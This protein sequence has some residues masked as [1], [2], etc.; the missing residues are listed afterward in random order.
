[1]TV[2][3][4]TARREDQQ[5]RIRLL[6]LD[7]LVSL[8]ALLWCRSSR[9]REDGRV[10][11]EDG[12]ASRDSRWRR[13]GRRWREVVLRGDEVRGK[14]RVG[15]AFDLERDG[16]KRGRC[17]GG[18]EVDGGDGVGEDVDRAVNGGQAVDNEWMSIE[19]D[20]A[21]ITR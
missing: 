18:G 3:D 21:L 15:E 20:R 6:N 4:E 12:D 10:S 2:E 7:W 5:T 19:K 14:D 9:K 17:V 11:I 8:I 1:M 13:W 16:V